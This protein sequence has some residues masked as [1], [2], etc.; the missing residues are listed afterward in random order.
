M[1]LARL[2]PGLDKCQQIPELSK[3]IN[4]LSRLLS[5]N[6]LNLHYEKEFLFH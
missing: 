6:L 4:V 1:S 2:K 5:L 3:I